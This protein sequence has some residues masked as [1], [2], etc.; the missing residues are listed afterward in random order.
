M[1]SITLY[2]LFAGLV[3]LPVILSLIGPPPYPD[4]EN[5]KAPPLSH[6]WYNSELMRANNKTWRIPRPQLV[7]VRIFFVLFAWGDYPHAVSI[8]TNFHIIVVKLISPFR[9]TLPQYPGS[10]KLDYWVKHVTICR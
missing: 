6:N 1:V 9:K 10:E 8:C 2:G 7:S 5:F 3:L 4:A